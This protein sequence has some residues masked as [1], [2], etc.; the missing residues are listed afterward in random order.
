[1]ATQHLKVD[2]EILILDQVFQMFLM[3]YSVN[4][5]AAVLVVLEEGVHLGGLTFATTWKLI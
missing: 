1:M 5:W 3:I 2:Q 4:S